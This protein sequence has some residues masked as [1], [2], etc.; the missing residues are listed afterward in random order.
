MTWRSQKQSILTRSRAK[1][2][3]RAMAHEICEG[4]RLQRIPKELGITLNSTMIVLCNNK[5][6]I[7]IAKNP[8]QHDRTKHEEKDCHFIKKKIEEGNSHNHVYYI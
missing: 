5:A 4:I 8:I 6:A 7:S 1:A 3:F 2:K